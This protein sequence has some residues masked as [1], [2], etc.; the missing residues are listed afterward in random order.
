MFGHKAPPTRDEI[1]QRAKACAAVFV[2]GCR[3]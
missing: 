2:Q 1:E 3:R